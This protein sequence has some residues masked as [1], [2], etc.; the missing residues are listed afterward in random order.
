MSNI[1]DPALAEKM[2]QFIEA[3]QS[4][5][6]INDALDQSGLDPQT[7][8]SFLNDITE[9]LRHNTEPPEEMDTNISADRLVAFSDGA[10][11][12]NPGAAACAVILLDAR[13]EEL[14][15]R[16][17]LLGKKT[18]NVAEYEGVVLA[19]DLAATL[20]AKQLSLKL[21]SELVVKQL[22]GAYK[23]KHPSLKPLYERAQ[24]LIARF[25][26]VSVAHVPRAENA[27]ADQLANDALDGKV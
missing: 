25:E 8:L 24:Q 20:G 12:G 3:L 4:G 13:G 11:R 10:S 19:L 6:P 21:D 14:L 9:T 23:V 1:D 17:K 27:A 18:N 16:S 5:A 7:A 15:R 26:K 22:N 2:I